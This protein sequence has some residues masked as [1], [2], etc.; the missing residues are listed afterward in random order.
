MSAAIWHDVECGAYEADLALWEE[1]AVETGGPVLDLGCGTGRVALHLARRGHTVVGL[2]REAELLAAL[3]RRAEGLPA[4]AELGDAASFALGARFGLVLAPMQ[5]LQLLDREGLAG[6]LR[7]T[8]E[9]LRPGALAAAAIVD[10][11]SIV[12]PAGSSSPLAEDGLTN[13]GLTAP[14]PAAREVDGTVSSSLPLENRLGEDGEI[15]VRRLRQVV[16]P[17]GEL[18][19]SESTIR[20]AALTAEGL[21]EEARAA[22]LRPAGRREIPPTADHVGSTVVLLEAEAD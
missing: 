19:E 12:A 11:A 15:V 8:R 7:C 4:E 6:C 3:A 1:L 21:E 18:S 13:D 17:A 9:H 16:S 22:G 2:D 5:L 14:V 10:E 20:L